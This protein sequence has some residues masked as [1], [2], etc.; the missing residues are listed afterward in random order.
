M[1]PKPFRSSVVALAALVFAL[2][3]AACGGGASIPPTPPTGSAGAAD[4]ATTIPTTVGDV[5]LTV[6]S[7]D[8]TSLKDELPNYDALV[9]SLNN[10]NIPPS[11]VLAAVGAP[12]S[13]GD[14]VKILGLQV[15][16]T[17]PG[18]VGPQSFLTSWAQS[19][20]GATVGGTN[21]GGKPVTSVTL[22]DG[23]APIYYYVADSDTSDTVPAD[24]MYFV[25]SADQALATSALQQL[26]AIAT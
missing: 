2:V 25:R 15:V 22:T 12:A 10:A 19:L 4:L 26:P 1:S 13:G 18:G 9:Q 17:T 7:G 5:Q 21:L 23:S 6:T 20:P 14:T 3:V 11:S 8:L 16:G 24:T